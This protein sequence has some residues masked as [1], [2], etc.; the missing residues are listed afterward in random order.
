M[1]PWQDALLYFALF[2][3]LGVGCVLYIRRRRP[4]A[5][6][7]VLLLFT[8]VPMLAYSAVIAAVRLL[9]VDTPLDF[10]IYLAALLGMWG[11]MRSPGYRQRAATANYRAYLR[12]R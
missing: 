11:L 2:A 8:Y 12:R 10:L 5:S 6:L 7:R 4:H 1:E 3:I 9:E